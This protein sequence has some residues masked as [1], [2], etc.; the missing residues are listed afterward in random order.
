[1]YHLREM[2]ELFAKVPKHIQAEIRAGTDTV[3]LSQF[4]AGASRLLLQNARDEDKQFSELFQATN[5]NRVN[6][7][8]EGKAAF[9]ASCLA[10]VLLCIF[11]I[12]AVLSI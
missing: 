7:N 2:G 11:A 8:R 12:I 5:A 9:R 3:D 6:G 1:S 10:L 4:F